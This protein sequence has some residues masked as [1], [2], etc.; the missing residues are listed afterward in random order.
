MPSGSGNLGLANVE[1]AGLS[2]A[3]EETGVGGGGGGSPVFTDTIQAWP[4][5]DHN[6]KKG[7]HV[8]AKGTKKLGP[9]WG[10]GGIRALGTQAPGSVGGP[11]VLHGEGEAEPHSNEL[12]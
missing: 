9:G 3:G 1:A 8:P 7:Q 5:S 12:Q 6:W 11:V 10:E 4:D 2:G